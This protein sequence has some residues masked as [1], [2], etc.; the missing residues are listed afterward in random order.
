MTFT[1]ILEDARRLTKQNS[2]S[3]PTADITSS[4]NNALERVVSLIRAAQGRWQWDD[5]NNTTYSIATT[6]LT[7]DVQDYPLDPTHYR[8]ERIE[9]KDEDGNWHKLDPIDET[10]VYNQ[11]LTDFLKT[12]GIP[13]Y[14]DK[15]NGS[16][17]L[18]PKPSYTQSASLKIFYERGPNYFTTTDTTKE[19]GFNKLF[20][21]LI[22]M[23]SAYDFA[24]INQLPIVDKLFKD[25]GRGLLTGTIPTMETQLSE[26]YSLRAPDDR[27]RLKARKNKYN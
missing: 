17:F 10:D 9:I 5:S 6:G 11:S 1:E 23:W 4:A 3:Y 19:P 25:N 27:I 16:L 15:N 14:Y 22:S 12:S 21:R 8:S 20:H 7:T 26:Y 24:L 13:R 18:Y 2:S